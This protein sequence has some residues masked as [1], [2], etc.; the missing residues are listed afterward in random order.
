MSDPYVPILPFKRTCEYYNI[1]YQAVRD[2][3]GKARIT[4]TASAPGMDTIID[5]L[6]VV[7][8]QNPE[9]ERQ[10]IQELERKAANLAGR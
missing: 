9:I 7:L 8:E 3:S 5:C 4:L 10:L 2:Q 1:T 6:M